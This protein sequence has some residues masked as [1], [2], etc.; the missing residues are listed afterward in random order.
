MTTQRLAEIRDWSNSALT[1]PFTI[2]RELLDHIDQMQKTVDSVQSLWNKGMESTCD[3]RD[4]LKQEVCRLQQRNDNCEFALREFA[5]L[6][7]PA[8]EQYAVLETFLKPE[9]QL[10]VGG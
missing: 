5:R 7:G 6:M 2:A 8:V 3:D 1:V 10:F 9:V 4:R